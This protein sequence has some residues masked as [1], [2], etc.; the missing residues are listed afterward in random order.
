MSD[1][2]IY[3][4]FL[5]KFTFAEMQKSCQDELNWKYDDCVSN[6]FE[7]TQES[8]IKYDWQMVH[9]FY[10]HPFHI[11][12]Q[13]NI[14]NPI[15]QKINPIVMYRAKLNLNPSTEKIIEHGYHQ[16]Y[17]PEEYGKIFTSAVY[18]LN[19]NNGYTR[20]RDGTKV[21]SVENRLVT[22]PTTMYHT[23][24][25]CTDSKNRLVLNLVY[26]QGDPIA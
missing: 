23:G 12:D 8:K 26:V 25:S 5:D 3:D 6:R 9:M 2:K 4:N 11:S 18:Y 22:F 17:Q 15:V 14:V 21:E 1:I 16:D 19:N 20:F 10:N 24:S 7:K 13:F